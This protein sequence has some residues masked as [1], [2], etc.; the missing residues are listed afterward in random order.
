[1]KIRTSILTAGLLLVSPALPGGPSSLQNRVATA[2][3]FGGTAFADGCRTDDPNFPQ[4]C[5]TPLPQMSVAGKLMTFPNQ[6]CAQLVSKALLEKRSLTVDNPECRADMKKA[7][8]LQKN[9]VPPYPSKTIGR[10]VTD[11]TEGRNAK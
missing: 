8:E 10:S 5:A 4:N 6:E 2:T 9:E 7:L 1:M 11:I 3:T